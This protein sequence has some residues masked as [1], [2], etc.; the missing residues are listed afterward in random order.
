VAKPTLVVVNGPP[1]SGKTTLAHALARAIPCPAICRDEIKEGLVHTEQPETLTPGD[2]ITRR[3]FETFFAALEL[4]LRAGVT[5]VAE[6]AFQHRLWEPHL[7]P[8]ADIA[9]LRLIRC[10]VDA[11]TAR[12]RIVRRTTEDVTTRASHQDRWLLEQLDGGKMKLEDFYHVEMDVPM[13]IVDTT[14]AYE[15]A[16]N[17]IV[18]FATEA[19]ATRS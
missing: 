18:A 12:E 16:F 7:T 14:N 11:A 17:E 9:Q 1:G 2:T 6:A 15:P 10:V 19:N 4:Y 8:L 3:T 13:V 5:I